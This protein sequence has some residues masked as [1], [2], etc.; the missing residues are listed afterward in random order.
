MSDT[1]VCFRVILLVLDGGVESGSDVADDGLDLRPQLL[2]RLILLEYLLR[3]PLLELHVVEHYL[4]VRLQFLVLDLDPR[5]DYF[6][7]FGDL[8][9]QLA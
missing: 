6:L 2:D 5:V 9:L 4:F 1:S 7:G 3:Y 8:V